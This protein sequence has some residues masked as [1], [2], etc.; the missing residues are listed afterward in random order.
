MAIWENRKIEKRM[1]ERLLKG[2]EVPI[3]TGESMYGSYVT[4]R[5]KLLEEILPEIK[6]IEKNL[7]DHGPQHIANV[8]DN[9]DA[10]LEKDYERIS[11]IELYLLCLLALFHDVGNIHGR[12]G[13]Y[14]KKVIYDIY[15][16]VRSRDP[17][18]DEEKRLV[19]HIASSHSGKASD[20][21]SDTFKELSDTK[22][23]FHGR[24]VDMRKLAAILRFA[25]ELAE[26]PQRTSNFMYIYHKYD[27]KSKIY[28]DYSRCKQVY[29]DRGNGRIAL[30]Y[31]IKINSRGG[32]LSLK[33]TKRITKLLEYIYKRII[34]LNQERI[35]NTYYCQILSAFNT[36]SVK[37]E[38]E[39][40]GLPCDIGLKDL[41]ITDL[42]I[43]GD[44]HK[45][46]VEFDQSYAV[47]KILSALNRG[48]KKH[49]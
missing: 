18:F 38:F 33:E 21:T 5:K 47:T 46:V 28:H 27:T 37:I 30:T 34:K 26:G 2:E 14:E 19:S 49:A 24:G 13:H 43:P 8:L 35:Y 15:N 17:Q 12:K 39:L 22:E 25:D 42:Q 40:D 10:L 44:N 23:G 48:V 36:L 20:G 41:N 32:K 11:D 45:S 1:Q 7:T 29:I 4:A 3:S 9:I 31:L 6:A 16:Y